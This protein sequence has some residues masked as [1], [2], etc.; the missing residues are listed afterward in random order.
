MPLK[1][2]GNAPMFTVLRVVS[3]GVNNLPPPAQPALAELFGTIP[4]LLQQIVHKNMPADFSLAAE[5]AKKTG[6]ANRLS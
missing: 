3:V 5:Q 1:Q 4:E 2:L 6:Y